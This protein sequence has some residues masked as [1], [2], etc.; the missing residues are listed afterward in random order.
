MDET[1]LHA[2]TLEDIFQRKIYGDHAKPSFITSFA[3]KQQVIKIGVF[4]RPYLQMMLSK[5]SQL[6]DIVVYTA[7]EKAY[8]NSILDRIDPYKKYFKKRL[9][10]DRCTKAVLDNERVVYLKDLRCIQGYSLAQIV[11]VDNTPLSFALQPE[12]GIPISNFYYDPSDTKL[13]WLT[14]YLTRQVYFATD[15]R[16][17][18]RQEFNLQFIIDLS[19]QSQITT[20]P[21]SQ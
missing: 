1:L 9:Y 3:D 14:Q 13:K 4:L 21:S 7:S 2:A 15:V 16:E 8:A 17:C 19:L 10:R 5:L 6:F 12:N 11:L 20:V 18:N